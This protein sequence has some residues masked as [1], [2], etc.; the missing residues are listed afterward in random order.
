MRVNACQQAPAG[1]IF[2]IKGAG[3]L[4]LWFK[5]VETKDLHIGFRVRH[6]LHRERSTFQDIAIMDTPSFG[7]MLVLD[8]I[9]QTTV[10]DEFF[11]HEMIVHVPMM[12]HPHPERVLVIG[13]GDGGTVREVVKHAS[14]QHVD[15]VEID[16]RVIELCK[17]YLPELSH[18]LDDPRVTVHVADALKY[19]KQVQPASY[20]VV[21]VD[22]SDPLGPAVGLFKQDF[23]EDV[24]RALKPG[25]LMVAQTESPWLTPDVVRDIVGAVGTAFPAGAHLYM[26]TVP[27]YSLG[28]WSFTVGTKGP[29]P[30]DPRPAADRALPEGLRYYTPDIHRAAFVLPRFVEEL[31]VQPSGGETDSNP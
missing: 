3:T 18:A 13:G 2:H 9:V 6:V 20:D 21:I 19:I 25:G 14:V 29:D 12:T 30:R 22:S 16:G 27:I 8:G 10:N 23:Y 28:Q 4:E 7:R 17:E 11:Y 24:A 31:L 1:N 15:M 5:E 26:S